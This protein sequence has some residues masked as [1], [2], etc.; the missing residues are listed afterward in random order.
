MQSKAHH[1]S[2]TLQWALQVG[3]VIQEGGGVTVTEGEFK[4][5]Q[6]APATV[7]GTKLQGGPQMIQLR[8]GP[9]PCCAPLLSTL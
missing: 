7:K 1:G 4:G 8:C 9:P 2:P 5:A 6:P 3:G